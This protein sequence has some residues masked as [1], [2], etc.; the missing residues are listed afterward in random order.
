MEKTT[1]MGYTIQESEDRERIKT[2]LSQYAIAH[3]KPEPT[4]DELNKLLRFM[5]TREHQLSK[6]NCDFCNK[7]MTEKEE[8]AT[9][10]LQEK[11]R[12]SVKKYISEKIGCPIH[13]NSD[14]RG[15]AIKLL[16]KDKSTD[17]FY[18]SWDGETTRITW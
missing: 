4:A 11:Y 7:N 3:G 10:K 17:Y 6:I 8:K 14:P 18:N 1:N 16:I 15:Q 9:N 12:Q 2:K 13:F 5:T